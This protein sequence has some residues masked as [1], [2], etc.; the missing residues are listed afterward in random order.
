[1]NLNRA[2]KTIPLRVC[3]AMKNKITIYCNK[4][5][6]AL[7]KNNLGSSSGRL[8]QAIGRYL[9]ICDYSGFSVTDTEKRLLKLA[10]RDVSKVKGSDILDI[11]SR[12]LAVDNSAVGRALL[13]K[14]DRATLADFISV[15]DDLGL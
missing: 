10:Y 3:C 14:I 4:P 15:L 9:L 8:N 1:M 2:A 7:L 12:V 11:E 5:I 13:Y 6:Q